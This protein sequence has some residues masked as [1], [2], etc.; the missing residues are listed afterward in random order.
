MAD[1]GRADLDPGSF[2]DRGSRVF[3]SD[4]L[5]HRGLR[6]Q[7]A[8]AWED[9]SRAGFMARAMADGRV[10]GTRDVAIPDGALAQAEGWVRVLQH[11]T[12]PFISY[13]YEWTFGALKD[14][15]LLQ[16]S[17]LEQAASEGFVLSDG[18]AYNVQW[19]G[20]RPVFIDVGSFQPLDPRWL[21][22]GYQQFCQQQLYPLML[23]ALKNVPFH[24]WLRGDLEGMKAGDVAGLF[25]WRD[26][27]KP[28]VLT[29]LWLADLLSRKGGGGSAA[30]AAPGLSRD[31]AARLVGA[32]ARRLAGVVR[33]LDWN[34]P[35]SAWTGYSNRSHYAGQDLDAKARFVLDVASARRRQ[36]AW[37]IGANDARFSRLI[38]PHVDHVVAIESD[39]ATAEHCYRQIRADGIDNIQTLVVNLANPSPGNGWAGRERRSL[40][41]RARPQLVLALAVIHHIVIGAN[42]RMEDFIAWLG[43]LGA[44]VVLEFPTRDDS[45]VR[46]LLST[47][48][49]VFS[50]YD[51][52]VLEA[53][54][55]RHFI[56]SRQSAVNETRVIY[57]LAPRFDGAA[58]LS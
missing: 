1:A 45:M 57:H 9:V 36:L 20:S 3:L 52:D 2:R 38:A 24:P 51:R 40:T 7:A 31:D 43:S 41:D 53:A 55:Q 50:D 27:F 8:Q 33:R 34:P 42:I 29:N 44:E 39:H 56:I 11:E 13:P 37:D 10:I 26:L 49:D 46:H 6:P 54:I 58:L 5:Y 32:T 12:V 22:R 48:E 30:T 4:G 47:R 17:L 35:E 19:R 15:A 23:Q 14:A 21:W 25:T 28:G 18:T 16:L